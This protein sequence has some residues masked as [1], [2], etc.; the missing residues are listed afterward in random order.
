MTQETQS[1]RAELAAE[2][3]THAPT[4]DE[5]TQS[6]IVSYL[7]DGDETRMGHFLTSVFEDSFVEACTR[8]DATNQELLHEWAIWLYNYPPANAWG[9]PQ[10]V[11]EFKGLN[12]Y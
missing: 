8:A 2:I 4:D 6:T 3:A 12:R 11:E 1:H 5:A 10:K 9:S 7:M